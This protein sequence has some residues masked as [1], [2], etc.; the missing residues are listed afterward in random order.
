MKFTSVLRKSVFTP[1]SIIT[2]SMLILLLAALFYYLT[3][4]NVSANNR[5]MTI[6]AELTAQAVMEK[7]DRNF[8]E[9]FGDVQ[10]FAF[11]QLA[12]QTVQA[13]SA[14]AGTQ[15]FINTM[16]AYYAI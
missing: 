4:K 8:Y 2:L 15:E 9:R 1:I 10:A 5:S 7:V 6:A 16:T 14:V 3:F 11:N 13:D 12:V